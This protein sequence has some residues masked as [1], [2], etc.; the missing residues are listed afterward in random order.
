MGG[1]RKELGGADR[2]TVHV[3]V[4]ASTSNCGPGFDTLGIALSLYNHLALTPGLDGEV[5]YAGD[6]PD[7][8]P[9]ALQ[10]VRA[11]ADAFFNLTGKS[12][13]GFAFDITGEVPRAR[14]LGS[15]VTLRAGVLAG[16]NEVTGRALDRKD[17]VSLVSELE[18]HPDNAAAAILGGF[19][20]ARTCPDT[21][22][23]LD[24]LRFDVRPSLAFAV[25][26]PEKEVLTATSRTSLPASLP[27]FDVVK[28]LNSLAYIVSVFALG[29]YERLR[30]GVT[31]FLH[32]PTRVAGI[33]GAREAIA[34]GLDAGAYS[35]WLS[36]SGSS[37]LCV[38]PVECAESVGAAMSRAFAE[39]DCESRIYLLK[40]ENEGLRMTGGPGS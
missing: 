8:H 13:F 29:D 19:C 1:Q 18:G 35:G 26:S 31:D 17:L 20:V 4:P 39:S 28:S 22:R 27:F 32:Q 36:G 7:F 15:S 40:A 6:L 23:F 3:R 14:G 2:Q 33:R 24:A 38:G 21:G 5:R 34:A 9:S 25:V 11:A 12:P 30:H 10:M 37:V 16:L